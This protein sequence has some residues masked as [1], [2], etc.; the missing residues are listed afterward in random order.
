M[1]LTKVLCIAALVAM[2]A[3][4]VS[5][6]SILPN[7]KS[8]GGDPK[9]TINKPGGGVIGGSKSFHSNAGV[10]DMVALTY[11][12]SSPL[13]SLLVN[14]SSTAQP[15]Q[16]FSNIFNAYSVFF[17][18]PG[19][20]FSG[21]SSPA[22]S[23]CGDAAPGSPNIGCPGV[24]LHGD[25]IDIFVNFANSSQTGTLSIPDTFSCVGGGQSCSSGGLTVDA[26]NVV[27]TPEPGTV[28]MFLSL[29]PAIGFGMKRWNAR[30]T[31]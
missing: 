24:I 22:G 9:L 25:I 11:N 6:G 28:L 19:F 1:R 17:N 8:G 20:E 16:G 31:A 2:S 27:T 29:I 23:Q 26:T 13:Y 14:I 18:P 4:A 12:G 15:W 5:A 3:V 30:Q 21:A 10:T 7:G